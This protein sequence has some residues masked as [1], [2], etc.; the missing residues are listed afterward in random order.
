MTIERSSKIK[1]FART[2]RHEPVP[3]AEF[4]TL[5]NCG[6]GTV[7]YLEDIL[8]SEEHKENFIRNLTPQNKKHDDNISTMALSLLNYFVF[9]VQVRKR[10]TRSNKWAI[11]PIVA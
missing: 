8:R 4:M 7:S 6:Y 9:D 1:I 10:G 5:F 11:L 3:S 2:V